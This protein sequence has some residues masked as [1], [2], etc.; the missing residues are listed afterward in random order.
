MWKVERRRVDKLN[1]TLP[2]FPTP[3]PLTE[4]AEA[5]LE[6][7][8]GTDVLGFPSL[9]VSQNEFPFGGTQKVVLTFRKRM[10]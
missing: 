10:G 9:W 7:L 1:R 6:R 3:T 8:P 4:G 5:R 2:P